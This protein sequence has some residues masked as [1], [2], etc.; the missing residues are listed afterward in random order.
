MLNVEQVLRAITSWLESG[1]PFFHTRYG[2]G[3]LQCMFNLRKHEEKNCDGHYFFEE[4]G[5]SLRKSFQGIV[6]E[7]FDRQMPLIIGSNNQT[8][9]NAIWTRTF[10]DSM[11]AGGIRHNLLPW[12]VGDFWW[13]PYEDVLGKQEIFD[14]MEVLRDSNRVVLVSNERV[15]N[16]RYCVGAQHVEIPSTNAWTVRHEIFKLCSDKILRDGGKTFLWAA[17]MPGKVLAWEVKK[18]F[19][20]TSHIDIGHLFDHTFGV[21]TRGWMEGD[22]IGAHFRKYY[23]DFFA[24]YVRR[25]IKL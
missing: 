11:R 21:T 6:T 25:F 1:V 20:Q 12:S 16:A 18:K 4:L 13:S 2:D 24:P 9:P 23:E 14:L 19:P 8:H 3:E 5:E 22:P 17:G 10:L 15:K 7:F